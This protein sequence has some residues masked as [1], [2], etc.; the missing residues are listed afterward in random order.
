MVFVFKKK[1]TIYYIT[2]KNVGV[3]H[4]L[5]LLVSYTHAYCDPEFLGALTLD[6]H[7]GYILHCNF[8]KPTKCYQN[9]AGNLSTCS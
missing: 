3:K 4:R 2:I 5:E 7:G 8:P 6:L 9:L 1:I